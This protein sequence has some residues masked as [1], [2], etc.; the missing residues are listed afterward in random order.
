MRLDVVGA[1]VGYGAVIAVDAVDLTVG[2]SEVVALLGP[3]GCG[4]STLL[5]AIAGLEPLTAGRIELDGA[6]LVN[7]AV[8]RRR[9]GLMFQD[10]VLFQHRTVGGNIGYGLQMAGAGRAERQARVQ[11]LLDL[12]GLPGYADRRVATLSG[13][14]AQ[15]VALARALAPNP[16]L[17]LLDEPLAALD[18]SLR[19]QLLVDL[20]RILR[21]TGTPTIFVT[22]DQDEAFAIADRVAVM[23]DG[24]IRQQG[25]ARQVWDHPVDAWVARFVGYTAVLDAAGSAVIR[26]F[27]NG[28]DTGAVALRPSALQVDPLGVLAGRVLDTVPGPDH[29]R[30]EVDLPGCGTVYALGAT[31]VVPPVGELRLRFDPA[32]ATVLPD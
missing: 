22:H 10:G 4:K 29:T 30:I 26:P 16:R 11:E 27:L 15:R 17:L 23:R 3:S 32:G 8:F 28:A 7:V 13:G 19:E 20:R 5:R 18:S 14:Q 25:S 24:R 6:D 2:E 12:V 1:S 31:G 9:F 21:A